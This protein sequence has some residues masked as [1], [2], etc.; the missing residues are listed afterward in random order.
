MN[1]GI[2]EQARAALRR[3]V[4]EPLVSRCVD[5]DYGGFLVDFD[6]RWRP[7]GPHNKTLEHAS[8]T[9]IA[10]ALLDQAMPGEGCDALVRDGCAFLQGAFWDTAYGGFFA[11]VDRHGR[12]SW[13]GL[14]HPHA[15]TY[16]ARAF[17]LA[18]PYL[19]PNEGRLWA[20]RALAWLDDVAWD[21]THGGYWGS[22]RRNNERYPE[23]ARLP[24]SNG[25]DV[26]GLTP[27]FK[28]VNTLGD[29]LETL[30]D[31]V[32]HGITGRCAD[33]L[34][35]LIDLIVQ[36]LTDRNGILPY[37]YW[38]DWRPVPDLVRIGQQF[39]MIHRLVAAA[40]VTDATGLV[41]RS[42]E[43]SDFC[44][45]A[46]RHPSGGFCLAVSGGG[47]TWPSIGPT[48]DLRQWWVQLEAARALHVLA[49]HEG[50]DSAA[51]GV[52]ERARDEQWGFV[53]DHYF[54]T[55]YG[56]IWEYPRESSPPWH[57]LLPYRLRP[58]PAELSPRKTHGWKDPLHE[59]EAFLA[60]AR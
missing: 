7:V 17:L 58:K 29:A 19:P 32:A 37:L 50:I 15:V 59:V 26:L 60:L 46:A 24:T 47:R 13:E 5:R 18:E 28:E 2:A 54:D 40:G 27:S 49:T 39:Q 4:L 14:K 30:T 12:P 20:C 22:F 48:T 38:P 6:E 23:R 21:T 35:W 51:R 43:L 55:R 9:T 3:H 57:A 53:R 16:A 42:R 34:T 11:E 33:R 56:G 10:L 8:R 36:R 41:T 1:S 44:L 52:Y 31:F 25:R 45:A